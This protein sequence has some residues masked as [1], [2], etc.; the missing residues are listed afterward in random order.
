MKS[1]SEIAMDDIEY[2]PLFTNQLQ[3]FELAAQNPNCSKINEVLYS[4][5]H[6]LCF[7]V[8]DSCSYSLLV[9]NGFTPVDKSLGQKAKLLSG[10]SELDIAYDP[11]PPTDGD[12]L[13]FASQLEAAKDDNQVMDLHDLVKSCQL[14]VSINDLKPSDFRIQRLD[15]FNYKPDPH[16]LCS[17]QIEPMVN[18][19]SR[20]CLLATDGCQSSFAKDQGFVKDYYSICPHSI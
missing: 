10:E 17:M 15:S 12:E 5:S 13:S 19:K 4:K 6:N 7:E 3:L 18:F 16:S 8:D 20:T 9:K 11:L 1:S 14:F 2:L